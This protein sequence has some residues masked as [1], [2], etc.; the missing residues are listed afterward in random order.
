MQGSN[1]R[2]LACKASALPAELILHM[3]SLAVS[4]SRRGKASTTIGA[5]ELNYCVR[6]G[7]RCDLF[8]KATRLHFFLVISFSRTRY[9]INS[10]HLKCKHNL[11]FNLKYYYYLD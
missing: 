3:I 1:L 8:A 6:Y 5:E 7:N 10:F 4:Y 11:M 2:P 9:F